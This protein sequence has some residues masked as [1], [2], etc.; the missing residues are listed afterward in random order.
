M[1]LVAN[2]SEGIVD[3]YRKKQSGRLQRTFIKAS[4]AAEAKSKG[5]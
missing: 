5:K 4:S 2:M 1:A 3:E